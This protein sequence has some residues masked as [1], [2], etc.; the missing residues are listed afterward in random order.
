MHYTFVD[1]P[2][3]PISLVRLSAPPPPGQKKK[4]TIDL[5]HHLLSRTGGAVRTAAGSAGIDPAMW[6]LS[7]PFN[8]SQLPGLMPSTSPTSH[9]R[10]EPSSS[11]S[12][13]WLRPFPRLI[14]CQ[15]RQAGRRRRPSNEAYTASSSAAAGLA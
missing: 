9:R 12:P 1:K 3:Q 13:P 15:P 4:E 5:I 14:R 10:G 6:Q 8:P 2:S 7:T 11:P